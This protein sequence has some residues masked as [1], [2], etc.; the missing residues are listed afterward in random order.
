MTP[1]HL[2]D[3]I[4]EDIRAMFA[5]SRYKNSLGMERAVRVYSQDTPIRDGDDETV[6]A[7]APPE[8]YV[9]VR[10]NGG[11]VEAEGEP[12]QVQITFV[13]C[14]CD[15]AKDRQ[16][17]RDA[18][19]FIWMIYQRYARNGVVAQKFLI[20]HPIEWALPE[21]DTHPYYYAGLSMAAEAP[22]MTMK[23]NPY[24]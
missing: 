1:E 8:P 19:H 4:A 10:M 21:T 23:E 13:A 17:F 7:T 18:L 16:G 6:D 9:V 15:D 14:V 3:A 11:K 2:L 12:M 24:T 20:R 22:A 5:G